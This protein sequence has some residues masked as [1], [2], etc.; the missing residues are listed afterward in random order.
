MLPF[1]FMKYFLILLCLLPLLAFGDFETDLAE[2][3][4]FKT[5]E[6]DNPKNYTDQNIALGVLTDEFVATLLGDEKKLRYFYVNYLF[7]HF[8][9]RYKT[10]KIFTAA[11]NKKF[12]KK[13]LT[14]E[15]EKSFRRSLA[16]LVFS[17]KLE[18]LKDSLPENERDSDEYF[19][20]I[21]ARLEGARLK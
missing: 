5:E 13:N 2:V 17:D 6:F 20:K 11:I 14:E 12:D 9:K 21:M 1:F 4:T 7:Y 10:D 16:S 18:S 15:Q 8:D 3:A 19:L